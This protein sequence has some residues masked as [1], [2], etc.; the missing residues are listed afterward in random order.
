MGVLSSHTMRVPA[1]TGL[2]AINHVVEAL[3]QLI[4]LRLGPGECLVSPTR[5]SSGC[6]MGSSPSEFAC[7]QRPAHSEIPVKTAF[8]YPT[9][10]LSVATWSWQAVDG[11][12]VAKPANWS[13]AR[14]TRHSA[15][16]GTSTDVLA[17]PRLCGL[18]FGD[19]TN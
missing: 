19:G 3:A 6:R 17:A 5:P 2:K 7:R 13:A 14:Q 11:P 15:A 8:A 1:G 12:R 9:A 4:W 18:K 16:R 10:D